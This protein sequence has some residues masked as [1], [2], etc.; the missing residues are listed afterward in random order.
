[1]F[2]AIWYHLD[3]LKN[4]RNT[5]ARVL[6]LANIQASVWNVTKSITYSKSIT[7]Q[8]VFF[9]FFKLYKWNQIAQSVSYTQSYKNARLRSWVFFII[10]FEHNQH[11]ILVF[12]MMTLNKHLTPGMKLPSISH[13]VG[14]TKCISF[15]R[16]LL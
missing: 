15:A 3:N 8:W 5:R 14:E 7:P 10:Y 2:C 13:N 9:T 12:L 1:M 11:V 4:V 6:L 16:K